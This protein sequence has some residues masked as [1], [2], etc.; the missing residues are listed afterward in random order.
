MEHGSNG[1]CVRRVAPFAPTGACAPSPGICRARPWR[2]GLCQ[3][4][5][6]ARAGGRCGAAPR[7][8]CR[9]LTRGAAS[10]RAGLAS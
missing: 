4:S 7:G 9:R 3:A 8:A 10:P 2:R 5:A 6:G 1:A